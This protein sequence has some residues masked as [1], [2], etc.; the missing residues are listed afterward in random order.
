MMA[1][2]F[3]E[4]LSALVHRLAHPKQYELLV[5]EVKVLIILKA[6]ALKAL[7][8]KSSLCLGFKDLRVFRF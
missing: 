4:A 1:H 7:K 8:S 3:Y 6:M 5:L 2:R